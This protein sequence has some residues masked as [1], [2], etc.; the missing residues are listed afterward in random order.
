M[1]GSPANDFMDLK[2][3]PVFDHVIIHCRFQCCLTRCFACLLKGGGRTVPPYRGWALAA[4]LLAQAAALFSLTRKAEH[5]GDSV[6]TW[7]SL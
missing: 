3:F 1:Q 5:I 2:V 7:F 6:A 4:A